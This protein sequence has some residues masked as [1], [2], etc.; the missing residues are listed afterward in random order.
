MTISLNNGTTIIWDGTGDNGAVVASGQYFIE[1]SAQ[2]GQGGETILT[3]HVMVMSDTANAGMGNI[4]ARP[5]LMNPTTGY[6]VQFI[7]DSAQSLTLVYR[8]Y[9]A[10]GEL[11]KRSVAGA[12]GA[13][14]AS[15]DASGVASGIY[16]AVVEAYNTQGGLIGHQNLKIVVM[17]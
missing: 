15:W 17:R 2:D 3:A 16:F 10:A 12:S 11:V 13:N 14:T 6:N 4:T 5:N 1:V 8:V 7:S 9:D